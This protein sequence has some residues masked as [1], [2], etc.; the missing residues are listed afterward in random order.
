M[1]PIFVYNYSEGVTKKKDEFFDLFIKDANK[2]EEVFTKEHYG[3]VKT[4]F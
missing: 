2:W 3:D 1:R 4:S